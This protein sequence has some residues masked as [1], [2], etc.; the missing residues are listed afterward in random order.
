MPMDYTHLILGFDWRINEDDLPR[1]VV[2]LRDLSTNEIKHM[3]LEQGYEFN[4]VLSPERYC[5][6]WTNFNT[7]EHQPCKFNNILTNGYDLCPYC[8]SQSGFKAAFFYGSEPNEHMQEFLKRKQFVYLAYF[9]PNT[10]KVG[11]AIEN[12]ERIRLIEQDALLGKVVAEAPGY[13]ITKIEREISRALGFT[14][15]VNGRQKFKYI[16]NIPDQVKAEA[17]LDL[18]YERVHKHFQGHDYEQYIYSAEQVRPHDHT[19]NPYIYFPE[20][21]DKLRD[22]EFITGKFLGLRNKY[23]LIDYKGNT[24]ALNKRYLAQRKMRHI[25]ELLKYDIAP[26]QQDEQ[27][28]LFG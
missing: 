16:H 19:H 5:P 2:S 15:F 13:M 4:W 26:K 9:Q 10:I 24:L 28:G 1:P 25:D 7:G 14:E 18:A 23:M 3:P 27:I 8:E 12:R 22:I 11:T 21:A 17:Q 6:G 20:S